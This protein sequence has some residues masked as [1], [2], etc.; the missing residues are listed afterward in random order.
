MEP[1]RPPVNRPEGPTYQLSTQQ[2]PPSKRTRSQ[3]TVTP[4][5]A[6]KPEDE[7]FE[8]DKKKAAELM[9]KLEKRL[10][11]EALK[12]LRADPGVSE[13]YEALSLDQPQQPTVQDV[14]GS[15]QPACPAQPPVIAPASNPPPAP[16]ADQKRDNPSIQQKPTK[17]VPASSTTDSVSQSSSSSQSLSAHAKCNSLDK[18]REVPARRKAMNKVAK[19][20]TVISTNNKYT[21]LATLANETPENSTPEVSNPENPNP[22]VEK[23][24]KVKIPPICVADTSQWSDFYPKILRSCSSPPPSH[25]QPA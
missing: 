16:S 25:M 23:P 18:F 2:M 19:A 11:P 14:A 8:E 24:K 15:S 20:P 22:T 12:S 9:S 17:D 21:V 4:I 10:S 1:S 5:M 3:R 6:N 7:D 13:L